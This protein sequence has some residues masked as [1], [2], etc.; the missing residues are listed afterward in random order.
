MRPEM[1]AVNIPANISAFTSVGKRHIRVE[2]DAKFRKALLEAV[3]TL[4][5]ATAAFHIRN[6]LDNG[7][8]P[9]GALEAMKYFG[10]ELDVKLA[11]TAQIVDALEI[12]VPGFKKWLNLTGFG[13]DKTM[14]KGFVAWAEYNDGRGHVM[15]RLN[16]M[17]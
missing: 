10:A 4:G 3:R 11:L 1:T 5:G 9:G 14:I 2:V 17:A 16:D 7:P 6:A 8:R 12:S 15:T 13:N